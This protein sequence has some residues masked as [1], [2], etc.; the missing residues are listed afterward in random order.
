MF[1][2]VQ[3]K[4]GICV[5][6]KMYF[7]SS[8]II[9][10]PVGYYLITKTHENDSSDSNEAN[11]ILNENEVIVNTSTSATIITT[12]LSNIIQWENNEEIKIFREYLR[13]KTVH[14]N[15]DYSNCI[16]FI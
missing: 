7:I 2:M 4:H 8:A 10:V 11:V 14:P 5:L 3:V 6:K 1:R 13:I 12:T 9:L 16:F 15:V